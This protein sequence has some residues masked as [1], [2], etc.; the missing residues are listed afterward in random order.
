[1]ADN[2]NNKDEPSIEE[3]LSSIRDII[4]DDDEELIP[5]KEIEPKA[6]TAKQESNS[7]SDEDDSDDVVDLGAFAIDDESDIDVSADDIDAIMAENDAK[8][9]KEDP[10]AGV[11]LSH[12]DDDL[13]VQEDAITDDDFDVFDAINSNEVEEEPEP[14]T[15]NE[16]IESIMNDEEAL[17]D[18]IAETATVGAMAKLAENIAVSRKTEGVTLEDIVR[19]L[20]RPMLKVWLD[21]NLPTIIDRVVTKELERLAE[22]AI[23]K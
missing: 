5:F 20:M 7:I 19:D 12:P 22:K 21:E 15:Q 16:Q 14:E 11:D 23:R 2:K 17:V 8:A 13:D 1:M 9:E 18:R 10:L 6:E 4:S 3:I